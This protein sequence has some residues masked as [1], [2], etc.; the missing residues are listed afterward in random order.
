MTRLIHLDLAST[1]IAGIIDWSEYG[2][3]EGA[4]FPEIDT[5]NNVE[6][7]ESRVSL[8]D[9]HMEELSGTVSP[10]VQDG[11]KGIDL[12]IDAVRIIENVIESFCCN[13]TWYIYIMTIKS[14]KY[15][16]K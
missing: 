1:E 16:F 9:F 15:N 10:L 6:I 7:P 3:D 11:N 5:P 14:R 12:Y 13:I 8:C 2:I 4:P